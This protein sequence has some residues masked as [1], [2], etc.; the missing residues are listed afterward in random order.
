MGPLSCILPGGPTLVAGSYRVG[1]HGCSKQEGSSLDTWVWEFWVKPSNTGRGTAGPGSDCGQDTGRG[2]GGQGGVP[3][4][5]P[6]RGPCHGL[7][8]PGSGFQTQRGKE[9]KLPM[10]RPGHTRPARPPPRTRTR[11]PAG[12][13]GAHTPPAAQT[14]K[15]Y[16]HLQQLDK[17]VY[18]SSPSASPPQQG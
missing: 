12:G 11:S 10:P 1:R 9:Q 7:P 15:Y 8:G 2:L 13:E 4:V 16:K 6:G 3:S 18:C 14:E 5:D 17:T